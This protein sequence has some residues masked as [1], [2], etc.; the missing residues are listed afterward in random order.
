MRTISIEELQPGMVLAQP[1]LNDKRQVLL[2]AGIN[3]T[4]KHVSVLR[5]FQ[6]MEV[7]VEGD[8]PPEP[9][10]D[11]QLLSK[12]EAVMR[13]AF[14]RANLKHSAIQELYRQA[15]LVRVRRAARGGFRG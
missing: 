1:A 6:I 11:P 12:V 2:G 13:P 9:P 14:V 8:A 4:E 10:I 5:N 7:T 3:I 15:L